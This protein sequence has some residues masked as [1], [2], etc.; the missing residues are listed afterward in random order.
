MDHQLY[1]AVHGIKG[2]II[3]QGGGIDSDECPA[4]Y[5]NIAEQSSMQGVHVTCDL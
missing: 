4:I 1:R 5:P 2:K 3:A